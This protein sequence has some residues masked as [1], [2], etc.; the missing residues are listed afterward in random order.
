[1][2]WLNDI[3]SYE[4]FQLVLD[5]GTI[6]LTVLKLIL[7][8][9]IILG[10]RVT[11]WAIHRLFGKLNTVFT[12]PFKGNRKKLLLQFSH[13][14][15]YGLAFLVIIN[16]LNVDINILL[17]HTIFSLPV[18]GKESEPVPVKIRA[19]LF[20]ILI[21]IGSRIAIWFIYKF[22]DRIDNNRRIPMEV[23]RRKAV[24]QII[25]YIVYII[26]FII[27]LQTVG[28]QVNQLIA[29]TAALLVGLGFGL[30]NI[31]NDVVS[32]ILILI[33]GTVEVDDVVEVNTLG[34]IGKVKSIRL[35]TSI[36]ET[37][38][39]VTVIVPNSKFTSSNV[40]NWSHDERETRFHVKI[41]VAYG[42]NVSLVRDVLRD[43]A[44]KHGNVLSNPEPK[45]FFQDFG[46][47]ALIFD[48]LFWTSKSFSIEEIRS[49][50]RFMIEAEFRRNNIHIPFPQRD[51]HI[52]S[53][54][55]LLENNKENAHKIT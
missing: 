14:I 37:P 27:I 38:D 3:L 20:S 24:L 25:Q 41:G 39:A 12:T 50:L 33:D 46:D 21:I 44:K 15:I 28:F 11:I 6:I 8:V 30:Q 32:G 36:I 49:D 42:S 7:L 4:I 51:L 53:D 10:S 35:R 47:S 31:F 1:M 17:D 55:R 13:Y 22:F 5:G 29:L 26:S 40:I 2:E 9:I 48:L 34:L 45:V 18:P 52:I 43:V 54:H 16:A 23:G 19:I